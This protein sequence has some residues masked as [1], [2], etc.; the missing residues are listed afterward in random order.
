MR[1]AKLAAEVSWFCCAWTRGANPLR[2]ANSG[3]VI[4]AAVLQFIFHRS[5]LTESVKMLTD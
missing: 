2:S 4:T 1:A 3:G 5:L